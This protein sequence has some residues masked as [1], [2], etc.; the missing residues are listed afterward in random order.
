[1]GLQVTPGTLTVV[2]CKVAEFKRYL[3]GTSANG[4]CQATQV[5]SNDEGAVVVATHCLDDVRQVVGTG[6][7]DLPGLFG[8]LDPKT[9]E[10]YTLGDVIY[11]KVVSK[12][13]PVQVPTGNPLLTIAHG[14]DALFLYIPLMLLT[15][16][17]YRCC[18]KSPKSKAQ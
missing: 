15:Y 9:A 18:A 11:T 17:I 13:L 16:L 1:M 7:P 5:S 10:E 14:V 2:P 6:L 8:Y 4:I 12:S 3:L